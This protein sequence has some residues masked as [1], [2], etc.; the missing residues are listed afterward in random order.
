MTCLK[1]AFRSLFLFL[2][3]TDLP[4]TMSLVEGTGRHSI[5]VDNLKPG[6]GYYFRV[7]AVNGLGVGL[8]SKSTSKF[9]QFL[10]YC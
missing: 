2:F 1:T 10:S 3:C 8:P 6:N 5:V 4:F 9:S 7:R